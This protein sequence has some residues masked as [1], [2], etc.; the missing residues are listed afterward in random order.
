MGACLMCSG[1]VVDPD[2]AGT[3]CMKKGIAGREVREQL[4]PDHLGPCKTL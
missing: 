2:M 1:R 4:E 3:E